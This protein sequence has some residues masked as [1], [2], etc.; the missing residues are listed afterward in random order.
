M[1]RKLAGK[2]EKGFTLVE[3]MIV[4][5]I[6][7]ILTAIAIPQYS[8]YRQ[9]AFCSQARA[10]AW[11]ALT[12]AESARAAGQDAANYADFGYKQTEGVTV[13]VSVIDDDI[14]VSAS[15]DNCPDDIVLG[16]SAG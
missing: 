16:A 6:I 11:N 15:H 9:R 12:A 13:E 5:A 2:R 4:I 3:L 1:L 8:A 14:S 10:D 7:G